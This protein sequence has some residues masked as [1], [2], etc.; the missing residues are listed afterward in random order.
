MSLGSQRMRFLI[1]LILL[2]AGLEIAVTLTYLARWIGV[3]L[4]IF[5]LGILVITA[6]KKPEEKVIEKEKEVEEEF[7]ERKT[8]AE[9]LIDFLTVK[10]KLT[11]MLPLI[12]FFLIIFVFAFNFYIRGNLD[13]G[14]NDTI[15]VLLG[16]TLILYNYVPIKFERERDFVLLFFI[17]LF[18]ILVLPLTLYGFSSGPIEEN[19]TSP[20]IYY[21]LAKPTSD[22]LNFLGVPSSAYTINSPETVKEGLYLTTT[23]IHI[24]YKNLGDG[25]QTPWSSVTIGISCTGLY[26]VTIFVSGFIAFILI[27]YR[28]LDVRV[29]SLLTL[30]VFTSWFANILRMTII[31]AV[32]SYYGGDALKWTHANLGIFIFMLW[33]GIFWGVMFKLLMPKVKM[34]GEK[35]KI[36]EEAGKRDQTQKTEKEAIKELETEQPEEIIEEH[37]PPELKL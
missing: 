30:G 4:M 35:A 24:V 26:S 31:V 2:L 17:F 5:G 10:R 37:E 19:S 8:L 14:V 15:T 6:R 7:E 13:I 27:E 16:L 29:A 36:E 1:G 32:G 20:Y 11:F 33:I 22:M 18:L 23:G 3:I 21:L 34:E 25:A 28:R 9:M 12:G